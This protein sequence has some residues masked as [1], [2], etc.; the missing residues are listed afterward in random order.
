MKLSDLEPG[1]KVLCTLDDIPYEWRVKPA[2]V[3]L[4]VNSTNE[5]AP[6]D[7]HT[8]EIR[9]ETR[10]GSNTK[11]LHHS[12]LVPYDCV[13][14]GNCESIWEETDIEE[15]PKR[16]NPFSRIKLPTTRYFRNNSVGFAHASDLV[17]TRETMHLNSTGNDAPEQEVEGVTGV[18]TNGHV[19]TDGRLTSYCEVFFEQVEVDIDMEDEDNDIEE[20]DAPF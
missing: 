7:V 3:E 10:H 19:V 9:W 2:V 14:E 17:S 6:T 4:A 20:E 8:V 16:A 1:M 18:I 11:T 12:Y 13:A 5:N 15:E